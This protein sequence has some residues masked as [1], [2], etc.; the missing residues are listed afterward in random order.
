MSFILEALKKAD[1]ERDRGAVP[2]LYAQGM[3]PEAAFEADADRRG[4]PWLWLVAGIGLALIAAFAWQWLM[5]QA[6][7]DEPVATPAPP[8]AA[9]QTAPIVAAPATPASVPAAAGD[10]SRSAKPDRSKPAAPPPVAK[11][12]AAPRSERARRAPEPA[13]APARR[14]AERAAA[15][16]TPNAAPK[17]PAP[18][19]ATD[20]DTGRVPRLAELPD[21]VRRQVPALQL[22]GLVYSAAPASRM[23]LVNGDLQREGST[24]A[25]GLTLE[26]INPKS[27]VFSLRGQRFEVPL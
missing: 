12:P 3:L 19:P 25:P 13:A 4:R 27:V 14:D 18:P 6:P 8:A 10:A 24:V 23:V 11:A 2:D 7:S 20:T 9:A 1:A 5:P 17:A 16:T 21:D 26:R 15:G 22:G